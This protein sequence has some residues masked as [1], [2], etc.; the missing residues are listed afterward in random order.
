MEHWPAAKMSSVRMFLRN[1]HGLRKKQCLQLWDQR[2]AVVAINQ[3][4]LLSCLFCLLF[5]NVC[6][7]CVNCA[8]G[9]W[10]RTYEKLMAAESQTSLLDFIYWQRHTARWTG[11]V[12]SV[13]Q[14]YSFR[15]GLM[16]TL[17]KS[18]DFIQKLQKQPILSSSSHWSPRIDLSIFKTCLFHWEW[19]SYFLKKKSLLHKSIFSFCASLSFSFQWLNKKTNL[20]PRVDSNH[21]V[22]LRDVLVTVSD[23]T[24]QQAFT[25]E[26]TLSLSCR[27]VESRQYVCWRRQGQ[28]VSFCSILSISPI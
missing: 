4:T 10:R 24:I 21:A 12:C 9:E 7:C 15:L 5:E 28:N 19:N 20:R 26:S 23:W 8:R 1:I 27:H 22:I 16:G 18:Y 14:K 17:Q 11:N 13:K 3:T 2:F 6:S 25:Q